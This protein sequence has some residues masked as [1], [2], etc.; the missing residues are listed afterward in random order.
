[1]SNK[2]NPIHAAAYG[3]VTGFILFAVMVAR[4]DSWWPSSA[5][6]D[7]GLK[8]LVLLSVVF[9]IMAVLRNWLL[10]RSLRRAIERRI[11]D[12]GRAYRPREY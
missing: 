11:S 8:I 1:M 6:S 12:Y 7:L 2:C 9:A 10:E 4:S 5:I 3:I